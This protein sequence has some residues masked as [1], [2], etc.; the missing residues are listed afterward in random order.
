MGKH[1]EENHGF[2]HGLREVWLGLGNI[3]YG[4]LRKFM[5]SKPGDLAIDG[6]L[7]SYFM[8]GA[9]CLLLNNKK[10]CKSLGCSKRIQILPLR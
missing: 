4:L 5:L 8:Y 3:R 9:A 6:I 2:W 1:L 7:E 10:H